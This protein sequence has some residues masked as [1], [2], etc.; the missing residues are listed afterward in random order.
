[1]NN[2]S[3][4]KVGC[5][6]LINTFSRKIC[7]DRR[8]IRTISRE[9]DGHRSSIPIFSGE[10]VGRRT[11]NRRFP[12]M[13]S[14]PGIKSTETRPGS[15]FL[16]QNEQ[17]HSP[18]DQGKSNPRRHPFRF[19]GADRGGGFTDAEQLMF[20]FV[21]KLLVGKRQRP[22]HYQDDSKNSQS[23]HASTMDKHQTMLNVHLEFPGDVPLDIDL[24]TGKPLLQVTGI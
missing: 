9:K 1:M 17:D 24:K 18:A 11:S 19:G 2:F 16:R 3:A 7:H 5:R 4:G 13:R 14:P 20:L 12:G 10:K 15:F 6:R 23:A 8:L 22:Q 21:G